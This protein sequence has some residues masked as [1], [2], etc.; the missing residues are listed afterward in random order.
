MIREKQNCSSGLLPCWGLIFVIILTVIL[1][2]LIIGFSWLGFSIEERNSEDSMTKQ[3]NLYFAT[4]ASCFASIALVLVMSFTV[5]KK[6]DMS[7]AERKFYEDREKYF[8]SS[9][10]EAFE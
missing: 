7:K 2:L 5:K 9:A 6:D 10:N 8:G 4:I 1:Q 3:N